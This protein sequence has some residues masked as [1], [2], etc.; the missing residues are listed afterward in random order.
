MQDL[1]LKSQPGIG[2][3]AEKDPGW[4]VHLSSIYE[5]WKLSFDVEA[6]RQLSPSCCRTKHVWVQD[7][8]KMALASLRTEGLVGQSVTLAGPKAWTVS[9]VTFPEY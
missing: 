1:G 4:P 5:C 9:E 6:V 2:Q 7:V 3:V 8:A